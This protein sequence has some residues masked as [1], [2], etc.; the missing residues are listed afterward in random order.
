MSHKPELRSCGTLVKGEMGAHT[1]QQF[2]DLHGIAGWLDSSR[3]AQGTWGQSG[4]EACPAQG[5]RATLP[6]KQRKALLFLATL[7]S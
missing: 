2:R 7:R 3:L 6:E 1:T 5:P 4:W